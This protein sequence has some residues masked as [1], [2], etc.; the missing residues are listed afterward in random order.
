MTNFVIA[1]SHPCPTPHS[2]RRASVTRPQFMLLLGSS[3]SGYRLEPSQ[4]KQ[5]PP[6]DSSLDRKDFPPAPVIASQAREF[7]MRVLSPAPVQDQFWWLP[8]L[9]CPVCDP[10]SWL[11]AARPPT[12]RTPWVFLT[13]V[14]QLVVCPSS[15]RNRPGSICRLLMALPVAVSS[16]RTVVMT[17]DP[18]S[19]YP[20]A[21]SPP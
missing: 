8:R 13:P 18:H 17:S 5:L 15:Y 19:R 4:P 20:S 6:F 11:V 1:Y 2:A 10:A 16:R 21:S 9:S 3:S 7:N 14:G 12:R